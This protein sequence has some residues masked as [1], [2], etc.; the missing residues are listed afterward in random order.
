MLQYLS[1]F[2]TTRKYFG[3]ESCQPL[4]MGIALVTLSLASSDH[5]VLRYDKGKLY[6]QGFI[7][8]FHSDVLKNALELLE[9][10]EKALCGTRVVDPPFF[11]VSRRTKQ[12]EPK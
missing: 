1:L 12:L 9:P 6:C 5:R 4:D 10:D 11:H 2:N 8:N 7:A 3:D